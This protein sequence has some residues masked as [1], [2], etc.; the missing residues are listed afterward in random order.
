MP[1]D[2]LG[3]HIA[4]VGRDRQIA[5]VVALLGRQAGPASV[6][7]A[8]LHRAAQ[9]EHR[10][11]VPV[12]GAAAAVLRHG[13]AKLRHGH[14]HGVGH[15]VAEVERERGQPAR[16]VVEA[17][18]DLTRGAAFVGVVIPLRAFGKRDLEAHVGLRQP[19]DLLQGLPVRRAWIGHARRRCI[20]PAGR[21]RQDAHG[22]E[23]LGRRRGQGPIGTGRIR[24]LDRGRCGGIGPHREVV[25]IA[26]GQRWGAALQGS[27]HLPGERHGLQRLLRLSCVARLQ[28]AI[29]PAVARALHAGRGRLHVVLRVEVGARG[30]G[31]ARGVHH[32]QMTRLPPRRKRRHARV[33]P[34]EPVEVEGSATPA[35]ARDRDG[36]SR[37]VVAGIAVRHHH[38]E[39][40]HGAPL[41]DRD[42]Q[43]L[44]RACGRHGARQ[45]R[46]RK[47]HREQRH[48]A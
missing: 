27:R 48:A 33:Q 5:A 46:R 15:A 1:H 7:V 19:R 24:G 25:E 16:E 36:G 28:I 8:A 17:I 26:H 42:E 22:V 3:E 32:R 35:R 40:I 31:R 20:G 45:E 37:R 47:A 11:A 13:A 44:A 43:L 18:G 38:V 34:E 39:S 29:Q 23:R 4:E 2:Q 9:H 10:V 21:S 41:E 12:V 14:D 6:D 30:I